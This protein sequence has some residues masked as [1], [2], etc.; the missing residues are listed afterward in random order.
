LTNTSKNHNK[1]NIINLNII[2]RFTNA[3]T[4]K[5]IIIK[6][7][8]ILVIPHI[9]DAIQEWVERVAKQP[10]SND[11]V[12]PD[13]RFYINF[14]YFIIFSDVLCFILHILIS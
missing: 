10:V 6:L 14:E 13:V 12:E 3:V 11:G 4:L 8:Y 7:L 5:T 1:F 2:L 9:T